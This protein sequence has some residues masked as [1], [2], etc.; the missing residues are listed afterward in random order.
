M[1][2]FSSYASSLMSLGLESPS[3]QEFVDRPELRTISAFFLGWTFIA[4]LRY[5]TLA[6]LKHPFTT[7]LLG[8]ALRKPVPKTMSERRDKNLEL[9]EGN[10][11]QNWLRSTLESSSSVDSDR[12][13]GT[14]HLSVVLTAAFTLGILTS[15]LSLLDFRSSDRD[16]LCIVAI[17]WTGISISCAKLAGLL[18]ITFD[19]QR[20]GAGRIERVV[21]WVVLVMSFGATLAHVTIS[22]GATR[23]I[24]QLAGISLCYRRH[25][26]LTSLLVSLLNIVLELYFMGRTF[27]LLVPHFLQFHHK[28]EVMMDVR[29]AR[30]AS[31]LILDLLTLLPSALSINTAAE[32]IPLSLG[33]LLVLAAFNQHPPKPTDAQSFQMASYRT[34]VVTFPRNNR[35]DELSV[36][37]ENEPEAKPEELLSAE[38]VRPPP[39]SKGHISYD[40][41]A[42]ARSVRGAIVSFAFRSRDVEPVPAIPYGIYQPKLMASPKVISRAT[43][44]PS[45]VSGMGTLGHSSFR[46]SPSPLSRDSG[47]PRPEE[48][49]LPPPKLSIDIGQRFTATNSPAESPNSTSLV[50]GSEVI[51][52]NVPKT[53]E[54]AHHKSLSAKTPSYA[55][56]SRA[57][58]GCSY[59]GPDLH[60]YSMGSQSA[61]DEAR[62]YL[63]VPPRATGPIRTPTFG[64]TPK[65]SLANSDMESVPA[66]RPSTGSRF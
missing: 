36:I 19:L 4:C 48:K 55:A 47:I 41:E 57:S 31:I 59:T 21:S 7:H 1:S 53:P 37:S 29:V 25:F 34:S 24:P 54:L 11:V 66:S 60:H 61:T 56:S 51:Q 44:S 18:R 27:F 46:A 28:V 63:A 5:L 49:P 45:P 17:A 6:A 23:D 32:F 38:R 64:M 12:P 15:F 33:A 43:H 52:T 2:F 3:S 10:H 50:Y 39:E 62:D 65:G 26:L 9:E 40:S 35:P 42:E 8:V 13:E 30:V 14:R 16:V 22:I 20:L 58:Q